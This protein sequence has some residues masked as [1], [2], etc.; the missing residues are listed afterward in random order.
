MSVN[1]PVYTLDTL[2]K[3][4]FDKY[5]YIVVQILEG[6]K[7]PEIKSIGEKLI[8]EMQEKSLWDETGNFRE[9]LFSEIDKYENLHHLAF[10]PTIIEV[11]KK[12]L[13]GSMVLEGAVL[14]LAKEN[15]EY[16]Q[17]WHRD[18]W[19]IPED[20]IDE[21]FFS[22]EWTHN[23][24][25]VNLAF[26]EDFSFWAVPGSHKRVELPSEKRLFFGS[27]HKTP[28]EVV[29]PNSQCFPVHPGQAI[30]YNN[31]IIHRGH[32][33]FKMRRATFHASYHS[34][35]LRP[36][37]H[38]YNPGF[39]TLTNAEAK[40]LAPELFEMWNKNQA[41]YARYPRIEDSWCYI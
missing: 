34:D 40:Q 41:I 2:D 21:R 25:Q 30:F 35:L 10:D 22:P 19:Q 39:G 24:I 14:L 32:N 13:G 29:M 15:N 28:I 7:I 23:C 31:N 27:K 3:D 12:L 1:V 36:T 11:L 17:G 5:G 16:V 33:A 18:V 20:L 6:N 8:N 4:Y 38:F 26:L 9:N 37:W